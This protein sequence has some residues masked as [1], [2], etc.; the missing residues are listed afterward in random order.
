MSVSSTIEILFWIL[1][2]FFA[3]SLPLSVW[4]GKLVIG[5]N[6][7]DF[8]DGNPGAANVWRAGGWSW[9]LL[10]VALDFLK[11]AIPVG[12][13]FYWR[14]IDNWP[15]VLIALAPVL[16]HAF[17]PFL[18][19]KGGK[20]LA[21]TFGIWSGLTI[22]IGPSVLGGLMA[23]WLALLTVEGWSVLLGMLCFLGFWI[24]YHPD[25]IL[26]SVCV[27]NLMILVWKHYLELTTP[28]GLRSWVKVWEQKD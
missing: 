12:L 13:A 5:V 18:N 3:G 21:V 17:S 4:L 2:S 19:F 22:W 10:A 16:G 9:G 26:L 23:F 15:L 11:G 28:P 7:R 6:I 1:A 14:G 24:V 20:A 25:P 27:G 8:G